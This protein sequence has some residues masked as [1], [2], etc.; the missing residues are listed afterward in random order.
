MSVDVSQ[1]TEEFECL[2]LS[3]KD[4]LQYWIQNNLITS[5]LDQS[6]KLITFKKYVE[7]FTRN[8][9]LKF[10]IKNW[11]KGWEKFLVYIESDIFQKKLYQYLILKKFTKNYIESLFEEYKE[12]F[13]E[14]VR[15]EDSQAEKLAC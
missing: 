12:N 4:D 2:E 7:Q 14:T 1:E 9:Y 15:G 5:I 8:S 3:P 6:F 13:Y 10:R 11:K